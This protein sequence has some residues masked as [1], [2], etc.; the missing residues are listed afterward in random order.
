MADQFPYYFSASGRYGKT[1]TNAVVEPL[2]GSGIGSVSFKNESKTAFASIA[3]GEDAALFSPGSDTYG[4]GA[5]YSYERVPPGRISVVTDTDAS[6]LT[7]RYW[8]S[9]DS[10]P[11]LAAR[12][13]AHL[14]RYTGTLTTDQRAAIRN[15]YTALYD[16]GWI[17]LAATGGGIWV[18]RAPNNADG[19]LNWSGTNSFATTVLSG[20]DVPSTSFAGT[21]FNG[22]SAINTLITPPASALS[23]HSLFA[24]ADNIAS[25]SGTKVAMGN[26]VFRVAPNRSSTTATLYTGAGSS[27]VTSGGLGGLQGYRRNNVNTFRFFRNDAAGTD[28]TKTITENT[29]GSQPILIGALNGSGLQYGWTGILEFAALTFGSVPTDA[30]VGQLYAALTTY[31]NAVGA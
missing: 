16:S 30:Q 7:L 28:T 11:N 29:G 13:D 25:P 18:G 17:D 8:R 6:P 27:I 26:S 15:L 21:A 5:G 23:N 3:F 1:P 2:D 20:A 10:D 9:V 19:L 4:P 22:S 31:R 14:A 12:A 24:Y